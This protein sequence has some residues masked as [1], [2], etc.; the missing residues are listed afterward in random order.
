MKDT[1]KAYLA[2]LLDGE[3]TIGLVW[4]ASKGR[5]RANTNHLRAQ[6]DVV[7]NCDAELIRAVVEMLKGFGLSPKIVDYKT[8]ERNPNWSAAWKVCLVT[9]DDK[10]KF[11]SLIHPYLIA[12][13]EQA[14]IVLQF[15]AR[16]STHTKVK[17]NQYER[18]LWARCAEL[19][20]RGGRASEPVTTG[21]EAEDTPKLQ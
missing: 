17:T 3:G 20:R 12:K 5:W 10:K 11:L 18:V 19:N 16:R 21:R 6:V 15:L 4:N 1:D 7:C 8:T 9:I 2:G 14:D 13:R